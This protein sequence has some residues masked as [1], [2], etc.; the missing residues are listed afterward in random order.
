VE[1]QIHHAEIGRTEMKSIN[2]FSRIFIASLIWTFGFITLAGFAT[3]MAVQTDPN[4]YKKIAEKF[5]FDVN[6][7]SV[8][9]NTSSGY[10]QDFTESNEQ[11]AFDLP[12]QNIQLRATNGNFS[13]KST[14][15][16]KIAIFATGKLDKTKS[17]QLLKID[18]SGDNL[19]VQQPDD[20]AVENL[21]IRMEIPVSFKN[22]LTVTSING[23]QSVENLKVSSLTL[24]TLS[25]D[26]NLQQTS[27]DSLNTKTISGN[28]VAR[29][30]SFNRLSGHSV[31]GDFEIQ[32]DKPVKMELTTISGD[33]QLY[34]NK[35]H[36]Y[37]FNLETVSGEIQNS[38][39]NKKTG[40]PK[41]EVSTTSGNIKIE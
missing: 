11:W 34:L 3:K 22:D 28:I 17:P 32:N 10:L 31:S 5:Q 13:I 18:V 20:D 36:P 24:E 9:F 29:D 12:P 16:N 14:L 19:S 2:L 7:H 33:V 6:G 25:G 4:I 30:S 1:S 27:G 40:S 38:L 37:N 23:D 35:T 39:E 41:I 8:H 26:I 15:N 21:E